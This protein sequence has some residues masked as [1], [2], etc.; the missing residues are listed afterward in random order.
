MT[1]YADLV[2]MEDGG[3]GRRRRTEAVISSTMAEIEQYHQE[4]EVVVES[5][6]EEMVEGLLKEH[7]GI[8]V[9]LKRARDALKGV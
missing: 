2:K 3:E 6:L 4:K 8:V 5:A 7:E 9:S 1:K